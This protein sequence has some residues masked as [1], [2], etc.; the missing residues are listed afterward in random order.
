MRKLPA[1]VELFGF[2][3]SQLASAQPGHEQQPDA[4]LGLPATRVVEPQFLKELGQLGQVQVGVVSHRGLR[5]AHHVQVGG[6]LTSSPSTMIWARK[7]GSS[8]W[9][10]V[11]L[12]GK[13][14]GAEAPCFNDLQ[15]PIEVCRSKYGAGK[16]SRTLDLNLGKV[17]LYQL[18]YSRMMPCEA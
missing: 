3:Q 18:S 9:I 12:A 10:S 14:K 1:E 4:K 17:A 13:K 15:T 16:E 7:N 11:A 5:L 2:G 8:R 6:R